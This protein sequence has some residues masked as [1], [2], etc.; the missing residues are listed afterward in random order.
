MNTSPQT[1]LIVMPA[2]NAQRTLSMAIESI[3]SQSY[4]NLKLVIVDDCSK[5]KTV[6]IASMYLDDHRVSLYRNMMNMGAY[7]S[8]NVGLY[9]NKNNH[10][11]YFTTHDS[12]DIS[13]ELGILKQLEF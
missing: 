13:F 6:D 8:R 12:D 2:Y 10:W 7:Y 1:L 9:L 3:L 4:K 11:G 5:D